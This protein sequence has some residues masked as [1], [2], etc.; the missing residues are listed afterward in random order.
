MTNTARALLAALICLFSFSAVAQTPAASE[1]LLLKSWKLVY[2]EE[3]GERIPPAP[4]Q[5]NDVMDFHADHTVVSKEGGV[6][7]KGTWS[8]D[9]GKKQLVVVDSATKERMVLRVVELEEKRCVMEFK[10]PDGVV[11]RMHMVPTN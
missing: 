9:S 1:A 8:Y 11:L 2:Y 4:E 5:R 3:S 10:D 6:T 7:E